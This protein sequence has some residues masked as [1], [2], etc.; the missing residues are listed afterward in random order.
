MAL[1]PWLS[2]MSS[3]PHV[4]EISIRGMLGEN[5]TGFERLDVFGQRASVASE[6]CGLR[7]SVAESCM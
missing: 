7:A 2:R 5:R 3:S 4:V 1:E 6:L